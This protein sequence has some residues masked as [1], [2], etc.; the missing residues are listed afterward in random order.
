[1][2]VNYCPS[3]YTPYDFDEEDLRSRLVAFIM[4]DEPTQDMKTLV[5]KR[6]QVRKVKR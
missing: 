4:D 2:P 5:E 3:R 1:M 6:W